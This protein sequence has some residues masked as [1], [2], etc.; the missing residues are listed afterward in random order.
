[1]FRERATLMNYL[2]AR[3]TKCSPKGAAVVANDLSLSLLASL[4][5]VLIEWTVILSKFVSNCLLLILNL[6]ILQHHLPRT[7]TIISLLYVCV[8]HHVNGPP[9]HV[10]DRVHLRAVRALIE[11]LLG[12]LP[13]KF[14]CLVLH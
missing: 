7:A 2:R 5:C 1:M 9:E 6:A 12:H 8:N 14:G 10:F 11:Q 13:T 3:L 4:A